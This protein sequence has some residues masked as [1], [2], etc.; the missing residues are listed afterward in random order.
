M[1]ETM[2]RNQ[3]QAPATHSL[4]RN[5]FK[6][7]KIKNSSEWRRPR[8]IVYAQLSPSFDTYAQLLMKQLRYGTPAHGLLLPYRRSIS[9]QAN[10]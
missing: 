9:F 1:T 4:R 10:S 5:T 6:K 2:G 3:A 8:M 7:K